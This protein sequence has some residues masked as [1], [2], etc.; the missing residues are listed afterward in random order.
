[1]GALWTVDCGRYCES[2]IE[3]RWIRCGWRGAGRDV[4]VP[5]RHPRPGF[6]EVRPPIIETKDEHVTLVECREGVG[7]APVHGVELGRQAVQQGERGQQRGQQ[8]EGQQQGERGN[9]RKQVRSVA[10]GECSAVLACGLRE[11]LL[12][13]SDGFA[14]VRW[15]AVTAACLARCATRP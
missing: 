7:T 6:D 1:M 8:H 10:G 4:S 15:A 12:V 5:F 2:V 11:S 14:P 13:V 9:S 3:G